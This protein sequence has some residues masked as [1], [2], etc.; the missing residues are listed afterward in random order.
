MRWPELSLRPTTFP[1]LMV[2]RFAS[3]SLLLLTLPGVQTALGED[4]SLE[5]V[6]R[7]P[8]ALA[9]PLKSSLNPAGVRV[10]NGQGN[11]WCEIWVRREI[12]DSG[13]PASP[14]AVYP[15]FHSG[16]LLGLM[17]FPEGGT[18]FRG[19]P[20]GKGTYTM[21]Y[22]VIPQ[23]GNHVGAAPIVDFVLL[24]PLSEDTLAPD[25]QLSSEELVELSKKASGTHHP[26]V[27]NLAFP[28][29]SVERPILE[30]YESDHW[31]LSLPLNQ[32]SGGQLPVS[33][34]V[35]GQAAG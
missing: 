4:F 11:P 9:E 19:L 24:I 15:A 6:E 7:P 29:D 27:I 25:A 33:I 16:V 31:I 32:K 12:A 3:F 18:D 10:L 21:R 28:P 17:R 34:I 26:T 1:A 23:D 35:H 22:G 8:E 5:E 13:Q 14:E 30:N 2:F 20:V